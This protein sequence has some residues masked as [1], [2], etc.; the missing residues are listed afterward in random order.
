MNF[1]FM[2]EYLVYFFD[3]YLAELIGFLE[4]LPNFNYTSNTPPAVQLRDRGN[5]FINLNSRTPEGEF[6]INLNNLIGRLN[7]DII[8]TDLK[9]AF[10]RTLRFISVERGIVN[11]NTIIELNVAPSIFNYLNWLNLLEN[12]V[13]LGRISLPENPIVS[14]LIR[15]N[16]TG[17]LTFDRLRLYSNN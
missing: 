7:L 1:Y 6:L 8:Q 15:N 17:L 16:I 9:S 14:D 12:P 4:Y 13:L 10:D 11:R 2:V 5:V 3:R